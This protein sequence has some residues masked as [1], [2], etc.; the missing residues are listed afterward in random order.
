[1]SE[2]IRGEIKLVNE[3]LGGT[4]TIP[5]YCI[6]IES[7]IFNQDYSSTILL[8]DGTSYTSPPLVGP[9]GPGV[10]SGGVDNQIILKD[11]SEDY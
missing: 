4:L 10:L 6:S 9:T 1:M 11:G 8:T 7:I 3:V 2:E 5:C